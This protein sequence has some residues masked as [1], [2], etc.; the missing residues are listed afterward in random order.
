MNYFVSYRHYSLTLK[1]ICGKNLTRYSPVNPQA[2]PVLPCVACRPACYLSTGHSTTGSGNA[3]GSAGDAVRN[4]APFS[5]PGCICQPQVFSKASKVA[6]RK[7]R[8]SPLIQYVI[9]PQ[10]TGCHF[11]YPGRRPAAVHAD[12]PTVVPMMK[13]QFWS[14]I[15]GWCMAE[16][17][18]ALTMKQISPAFIDLR[19]PSP[20]QSEKS[21]AVK[22]AVSA[23]PL[24]RR[25]DLRR[26]DPGAARCDGGFISLCSSPGG[27]SGDGLGRCYGRWSLYRAEQNRDQADQGVVSSPPVSVSAHEK[28]P[29]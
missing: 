21:K 20:S 23:S 11:R 14:L 5:F 17:T 29:G 26:G 25:Y 19:Q 18:A 6:I 3:V 16:T 24:R 4:Q 7:N 2:A 8:P 9:H 27:C 10:R 15:P 22:N 1:T 13:D 12:P 28:Y